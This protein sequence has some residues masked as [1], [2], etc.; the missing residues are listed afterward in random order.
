MSGPFGACDVSFAGMEAWAGEGLLGLFLAC[1]LA[2]TVVPFSS[3]AVVLAAALGPW[4]DAQ[5][6][7]TASLGNWLGGLTTYGLGWLGNWERIAR[8]LRMRPAKMERWEGPVRRHGAWLGLLCWLPF[9]GD[10]LA[11]ALGLFR[12]KPLP[13][14]VLMLVGKAARYAVVVGVARAWL[15]WP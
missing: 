4:S 12:V 6:I 10:P 13:V 14:A 3:E 1:F 8:W 9:V 7:L 11:L 2:A 5:V 15:T